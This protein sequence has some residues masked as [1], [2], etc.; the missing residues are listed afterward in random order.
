MVADIQF[1]LALSRFLREDSTV[2][3]MVAASE[4]GRPAVEAI[5]AGLLTEFGDRVRPNGVRQRIGRLV[6]PI[7]ESQGF[8][9]HPHPKRRRSRCAPFSSGTVYR[10]LSISAVLHRYG[11]DLPDHVIQRELQHAA[12]CVIGNPPFFPPRQRVDWN[13]LTATS[14]PDEPPEPLR[15]FI[16]AMNHELLQQANRRSGGLPNQQLKAEDRRRLR[17]D[18]LSQRQPYRHLPRVRTALIVGA[19]YATGVTIGETA[20]LLDFD[21]RKVSNWVKNRRLYGTPIGLA[22]PTRLA[23]FQFDGDGLVPKVEDVLPVLDAAMH[24][25]GVFNWFTRPNPDLALE[26]THFE[27]TSPRDWLRRRYA[28]GPVCRLAAAVP[29]GIAA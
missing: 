9:P 20:R 24:P 13:S 8:E 4:S 3:A 2:R 10:P 26:Q 29:L 25:V 6:R 19:L 23:L 18:D 17:L 14:Q 27:P 15:T 1:H 12:Q 7:M 22:K 5:G 21:E 28:S 16:A 11:I